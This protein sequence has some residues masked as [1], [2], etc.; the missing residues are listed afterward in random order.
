MGVVAG[1]L[2]R[3][4]PPEW[5]SAKPK[6]FA[7]TMALGLSFSMMII[8]N[9]GIRGLLPRSICLVCLVLM[10]SE[11]VLGLCI[12]CELHAF[13]VRRGWTEKDPAFEVCAHGV[14][15]VPGE[16]RRR[17]A[18]LPGSAVEPRCRGR[19]RPSSRPCRF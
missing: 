8:T 3:R 19:Q 6:R 11:S 1:A 2:T 17:A 16:V 9:S 12:G 13:L 15:E 4:L 14:C 5:V 18:G 7:W 10:W